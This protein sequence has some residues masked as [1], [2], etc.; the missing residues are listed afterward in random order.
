MIR[1]RPPTE[2]GGVQVTV[3]VNNN[4][5]R[6]YAIC[7]QEAPEVFQLARRRL[8]VDPYPTEGLLDKVRTA[9]RLCPMQAIKLRETTT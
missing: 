4:H 5:C 1:R 9:A 3:S 2:P 6:L 8:H 7:Q